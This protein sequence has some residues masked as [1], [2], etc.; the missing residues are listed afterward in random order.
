MRDPLLKEGFIY[1]VFTKS[2]EGYKVFRKKTEY[3]RFLET[4]KFYR[5]MS[6]PARFSVYLRL[7]DRERFFQN[8]LSN[9][10]LLVD[11]LAYCL[12]PTHIHFLLVPLHE[13]GISE[14]MKRIL[15][16]YSKYFN[17]K[18]DRKGPLWQSRFKHVL[19]ETEEQLMHT[20]RYIHLN[21]ATDHLVEKPED[22]NYSSYREFIGIED[23][24][25]CSFEKY[26]EIETGQY[27]KFVEEQIDYQRALKNARI[28]ILPH[29]TW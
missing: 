15:D 4:M 29:P 11:I 9:C 21:P 3:S 18:N 7:K 26:M 5:Y 20:T 17:L 1:H 24:R 14:Y 12:M 10:D 22:W 2:I 23:D 19:I 27:K 13:G 8:Y 16:S 25:I 6:P 28:P